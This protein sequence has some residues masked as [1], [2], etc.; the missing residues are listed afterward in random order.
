MSKGQPDL[1]DE[2]REEIRRIT[3]AQQYVVKSTPFANFIHGLMASAV[4]GLCIIVWNLSVT[5]AALQATIGASV[6]NYDRKFEVLFDTRYTE[7][8]ADFHHIVIKSRIEK[9]ED[10]HAEGTPR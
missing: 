1:A 4:T 7:K 8:Q 10:V 2:R 5:M 3:D 9:L 6:N